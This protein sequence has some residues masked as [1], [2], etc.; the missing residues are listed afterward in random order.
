MPEGDTIFRLAEQLRPRLL[1]A[2]VRRLHLHRTP[3]TRLPKLPTTV[4][5]V[6]AVGKHLLIR[7][8]T[9]HVFDSHLKMN[10]SWDV[11]R[12]G[13][14]WRE[15]RGAMRA[16]IE[17]DEV[18][19][20]LFSTR[21]VRI[22]DPRDTSTKPWERL[23]PD[24]CRD[25]VD[26]D[27]AVE[28]ARWL[29]EETEIAEVLLDQRPAC[30][31]GNVY[32]SEVLWAERVHPRTPIGELDDDDLHRLYATAN[33]LLRANLDRSKRVTHGRGL[34]V[35]GR[36]RSS[37]PRCHHRVQYTKQGGLDRS[38]YWCARCQVRP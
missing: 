24:L 8:G 30:G 3:P 15:P 20:V 22:Y 35:Y 7:F 1:D 18:E 21:D 2:E 13:Q 28:R 16:L 23:G 34:A 26:L 19:A 14:R 32:K 5:E 11:H 29:P 37:C 4:D 10:G 27:Q 12:P 36:E 6:S 25:D 9:G 38:T 17:T 33:R 31:I